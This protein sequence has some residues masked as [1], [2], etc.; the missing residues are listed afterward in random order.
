MPVSGLEFGEGRA[1]VGRGDPAG[2]VA[3][4]GLGGRD[5]FP[6]DHADV[7][8]GGVAQPV[9]GSR[10]G[11]PPMEGVGRPAE[12]LC[13]TD[14]LS[15]TA[16]RGSERLGHTCRPVRLRGLGALAAAGLEMGISRCSSNFSYNT[17]DGV[18]CRSVRQRLRMPSRRHAVSRANARINRSSSGSRLVATTVAKRLCSSPCRSARCGERRLR[19][20]CSPAAGLSRRWPDPSLAEGGW[21]RCPTPVDTRR[22]D[23]CRSVPTSSL[24]QHDDVGEAAE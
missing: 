14:G 15:G 23:S 9:Q 4:A 5:T 11:S 12:R 7:G 3:V 19:G 16:R 10:R 20:R 22:S 6:G 17:T 1:G 18:G 2:L 24:R 13:R 21:M 8:E